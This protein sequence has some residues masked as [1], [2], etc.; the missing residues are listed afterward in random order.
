MTSYVRRFSRESADTQTD[1]QTAW[2]LLPWL[3]TREVKKPSIR[4]KAFPVGVSIFLSL[5]KTRA[6]HCMALIAVYRKFIWASLFR[7]PEEIHFLL[8]RI[9]SDWFRTKKFSKQPS[10]SLFNG[11][12]TL[13]VLTLPYTLWKLLCSLKMRI[14]FWLCCE[15]FPILR[16]NFVFL[17]YSK[18]D[19]QTDWQLDRNLAN[20]NFIIYISNT[21]TIWGT[22][23]LDQE[24]L[25]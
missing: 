1:T 24:F 16:S 9:K 3:L 12:I 13:A 11:S 10:R 21:R 7:T 20:V 22:H 2:I 18:D 6:I 25:V 19:I 15:E 5:H 4:A 8:V 14:P 23:N 17:E